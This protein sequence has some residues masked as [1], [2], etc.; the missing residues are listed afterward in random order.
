MLEEWDLEAEPPPTSSTCSLPRLHLLL[1]LQLQVETPD[2]RHPSLSR[3][4]HTF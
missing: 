4:T 2:R 3:R 1:R